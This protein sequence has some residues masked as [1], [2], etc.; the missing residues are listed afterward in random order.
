MP[1]GGHGFAGLGS[2]RSA[3]L[4]GD[5]HSCSAI[6]TTGKQISG[7]RHPRKRARSIVNHV[8]NR[9]KNDAGAARS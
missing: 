3:R 9:E 1:V 4:L 8:I 6:T 7:S 5:S 2:G